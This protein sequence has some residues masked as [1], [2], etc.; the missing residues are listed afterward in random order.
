MDKLYAPVRPNYEAIKGFVATQIREGSLGEG[1][2]IYDDVTEEE[3][4]WA[5]RKAASHEIVTEP[6]GIAGLALLKRRLEYI[7]A[8]ETILV[9]NTGRFY[10]HPIGN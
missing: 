10:C 7:P 4:E 6:S 5:C 1:S 2:G 9:I 8:G 3:A